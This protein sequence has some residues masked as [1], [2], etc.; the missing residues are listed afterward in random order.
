MENKQVTLKM[1]FSKINVLRFS[2]YDVSQ[3]DTTRD[4]LIEYQSSF[5]VSAQKETNE[6]VTLADIKLVLLETK[7]LYADLKVEC[8]YEVL[9]FDFIN[10]DGTKFE[11]PKDLVYHLISLS[12]STIRGILHE[13]LKGTPLQ[14]EVFP[15]IDPKE[16]IAN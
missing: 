8:N 7:E 16:M 11:L 4:A 12:I 13:K 14:K 3:F 15:L 9:P 10:I 2:Q 5:S 6:I 1:R